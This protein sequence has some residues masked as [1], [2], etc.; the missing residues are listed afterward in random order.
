VAK[1]KLLVLPVYP[2]AW[3]QARKHPSIQAALAGWHTLM[4]LYLMRK[5]GCRYRQMEE[6]V[7]GT[8]SMLGRIAQVIGLAY[9]AAASWNAMARLGVRIAAACRAAAAA[10]FAALSRTRLL[11][12]VLRSYAAQ[13]D[14]IER[15][16]AGPVSDRLRG[17]FQRWSIKFSAEYYE[18][19]E[20]EHAAAM[21]A[22]PSQGA[23]AI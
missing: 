17:F 15:P 13:Y 16:D 14:R 10:L 1:S 6:M 4:M 20:R 21:A 12:P 7:R 9:L 3:P 2:A 22:A 18:A 11:G 5:L 23:V 19:K 8:L